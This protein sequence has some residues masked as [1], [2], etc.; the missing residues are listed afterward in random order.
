[1]KATRRKNGQYMISVRISVSL[2]LYDLAKFTVA[3]K[4]HTYNHD[5]LVAYA[6]YEAK[7][8]IL[9]RVKFLIEMDGTE[10]AD[11][12]IGDNDLEDTVEAVLEVL[13]E[14]F[15]TEFPRGA[16]WK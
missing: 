7:A 6:Q 12:V 2:G 13:T 11:Y 16:T 9:D 10:K 4:W 14:R 5:E 15:K 1:M 3:D 8:Q